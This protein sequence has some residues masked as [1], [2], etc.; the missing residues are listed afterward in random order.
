MLLMH[1]DGF[2]GSG[3]EDDVGFAQGP[4]VHEGIRS[5]QDSPQD[6]V[7][8]VPEGVA[9]PR[10]VIANVPLPRP[11][12]K[13]PQHRPR[14]GEDR[15]DA[16][17]LDRPAMLGQRQSKAQISGNQDRPLGAGMVD[18]GQEQTPSAI[19]FRVRPPPDGMAARGGAHDAPADRQTI[20]RSGRR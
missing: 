10:E 9:Q 5:G 18:D 19:D 2:S 4:G 12:S 16:N 15:L 13:E 20:A 14:L 7:A 8:S 3:G 1:R 17:F 6:G 11:E